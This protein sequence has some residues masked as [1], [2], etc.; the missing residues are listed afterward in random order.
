MNSRNTHNTLISLRE[1]VDTRFEAQKEA[2]TAALTAADRAVNK[3]ELASEKR[4][5]SVNEFR[6]ALNDSARLLM[7]RAEAEQRMLTIESSIRDLK[8]SYAAI[9]NREEGKS[10]GFL[11]I[12]S[13]LSLI[14]NAVLMVYYLAR[15]HP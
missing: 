11:K 1:Y 3:A 10:L 2:V 8:T 9:D 4:F 6:A 12:V 5:D 13:G 7:P 14:A 15:M